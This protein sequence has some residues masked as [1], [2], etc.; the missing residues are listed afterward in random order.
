MLPEELRQGDDVGHFLTEERSVAG[1]A[2]LL[3]ARAGEHRSA[4]RIAN[5]ILHVGAIEADAAR[6][7]AVEV[8]RLGLRVTVA[9][10]RRPEVI[11]HDEE[12]VVARRGGG[13]FDAKTQNAQR[14]AVKV[15]VAWCDSS[16]GRLLFLLLLC[17]GRRFAGQRCGVIAS[18][19]AFSTE[20]FHAASSADIFATRSGC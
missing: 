16:K 9:A 2:V 17:L 18:R 12:D 11:G 5:G 8:G 19:E 7:E 6:G 4:A 3:R 10:H 14:S 15:G 20:V 13:E 1:D